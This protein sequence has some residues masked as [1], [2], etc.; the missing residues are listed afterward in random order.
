[1]KEKIKALLRPLVHLTVMAGLVLSGMLLF[2]YVYLPVTTK[3]GQT[4]T[5][6]DLHGVKEA[7]LGEFLTSRN[8]RFEISADSGYSAELPPLAV[9]QQHPKAG[10]KVKEG[11]KVYITLNAENPPLTKMPNL[12]DGS[13]KSAEIL[14]QSAGLKRGEITY[15]PDRNINAVLRQEY[16]GKPIKEGVKIPKGEKIDLIV[17]NGVGKEKFTLDNLLDKPLDEVRL[18]LSG[19]SLKIGSIIHVDGPDSLTNKV[20]RQFPEVGESVRTGEE[21]D[22]W[23]YNWDQ[24][25]D[26]KA[27]GND[28]QP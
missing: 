14:L 25:K 22:L 9:L 11:R 12:V 20:A 4:I 26:D 1:M 3:K 6:P 16:K 24:V 2:F 28:E 7:R 10:A 8:L 15:E 27:S 5:V 17:G 23:V 19:S 21:V 18:Q 13:L